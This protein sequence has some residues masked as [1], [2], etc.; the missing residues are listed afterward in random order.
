MIRCVCKNGILLQ[1]DPRKL[2]ETPRTL[3][4]G[5]GSFGGVWGNLGKPWGA[6]TKLGEAPRRPKEASAGLK[7]LLVALVGTRY[8]LP[9]S[10]LSRLDV[11]QDFS[12]T[13][14][15]F[16][17]TPQSYLGPLPKSEYPDFCTKSW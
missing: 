1:G 6:P 3:A 11:P 13:S 4:E 5:Q 9:R 14:P 8:E 15:S 7:V 12:E 2:G 17:E 16:P 10:S